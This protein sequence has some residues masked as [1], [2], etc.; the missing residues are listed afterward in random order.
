VVCSVH[1]ALTS[2][3]AFGLEVSAEAH[4]GGIW[5]L[6]GETKRL[7]KG[8]SRNRY[9]LAIWQGQEMPW[10]LCEFKW[11]FGRQGFEKDAHNLAKAKRVL[12][13][14]AI[15]CYLAVK[16][17]IDDLKKE[18][19]RVDQYLVDTHGVTCRSETA[20]TRT[21]LYRF[22]KVVPDEHVYTR[23]DAYCL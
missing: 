18:M 12:G 11:H 7:P 10:A 21:R 5:A 16:P 3:K 22:G 8:S 14:Q 17:S 13:V 4:Q 1:E 2:Q 15:L 19:D 23:V 6:F 9:D 20:E